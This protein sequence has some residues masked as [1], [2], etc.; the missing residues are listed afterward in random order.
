MSLEKALEANTAALIALT[1]A[2]AANASA[3]A[4]APAAAPAPAP[5][6]A[7][8]RTR[9]EAVPTPAAAPVAAVKALDKQGLIAKLTELCNIPNGRAECTALC[10]KHGSA[11]KNA[12]GL[13]PSKY[14]AVYDEAQALIEAAALDPAA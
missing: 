10:V 13:D 1:A 4:A 9:P 11:T 8:T 3:P 2:L 6:P 5:A 7:R 14:Q 12:S